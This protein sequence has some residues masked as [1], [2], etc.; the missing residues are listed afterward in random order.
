MGAKALPGRHLGLHI[1]TVPSRPPLLH[2]EQSPVPE[3]SQADKSKDPS[4]RSKS[5]DQHA[6]LPSHEVLHDVDPIS[7]SNEVLRV[8][9]RLLAVLARKDCDVLQ[10]VLW[11]PHALDVPSSVEARAVALVE[12]GLGTVVIIERGGEVDG[13]WMQPL[14]SVRCLG[15][16]A[17]DLCLLAPVWESEVGSER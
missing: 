5:N 13:A 8:L 12:R 15:L 10:D 2:E 14:D 16:A 4:H 1:N 3:P 9:L 7:Q 6:G 17:V 11:L